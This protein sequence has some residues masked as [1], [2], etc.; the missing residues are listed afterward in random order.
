VIGGGSTPD[1]QLPT[2]LIAISTPRHSAAQMEARLRKPR[3]SNSAS[4]TSPTAPLVVARIEDD[5]LILDLRTVHPD[6][7]NEIASALVAALA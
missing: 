5:H 6:E 1:Q 7:E 3:A 4:E 2:T